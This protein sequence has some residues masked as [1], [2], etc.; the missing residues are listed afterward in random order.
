[1]LAEEA[2]AT[3][4]ALKD[5]RAVNDCVGGEV[6]AGSVS[7]RADRTGVRADVHVR[8][9][10]ILQLCSAREF[11]GAAEETAAEIHAR[12]WRATLFFFYSA[13]LAASNSPTSLRAT[14]MHSHSF[15]SSARFHAFPADFMH[16]RISQSFFNAF[17]SP[18]SLKIKRIS[19][20]KRKKF[21]NLQINLKENEIF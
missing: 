21:G 11:L 3:A 12:G 6:L 2:G 7:A 18:I 13:L 4:E 17:K 9:H 1:M 5:R 16:S 20:H 8:V 14:F 15:T 19:T 10:V